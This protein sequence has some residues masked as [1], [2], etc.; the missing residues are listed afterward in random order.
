MLV[1]LGIEVRLHQRIGYILGPAHEVVYS[2]L[3]TATLAAVNGNG[4]S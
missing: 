1:E 2:L 4:Y 3:R